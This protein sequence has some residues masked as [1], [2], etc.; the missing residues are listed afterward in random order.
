MFLVPLLFSFL[1][2][3]LVT[4]YRRFFR[5]AIHYGDHRSVVLPVTDE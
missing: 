3:E 2:R 4:R 5:L 1:N